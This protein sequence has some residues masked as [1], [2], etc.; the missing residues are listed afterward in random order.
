MEIIVWFNLLNGLQLLGRQARGEF[1][2]LFHEPLRIGIFEF[3]EIHQLPSNCREFLQMRE[4]HL[5][6]VGFGPDQ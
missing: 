6:P 4:W 5:T 2:V 1:V 3:G